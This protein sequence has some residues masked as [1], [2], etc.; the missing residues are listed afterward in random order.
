M[1][2]GRCEGKVEFPYDTSH[3]ITLEASKKKNE[4]R[5][6]VVSNHNNPHLV[7][8]AEF[9]VS[10]SEILN[11]SFGSSNQTVVT[12]AQGALFVL[13]FAVEDAEGSEEKNADLA[14]QVDGVAGWVSRGVFLGVCPGDTLVH[15]IGM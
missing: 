15:S 10:V 11:L 6:E 5:V 12:L 2:R 7:E 8:V 13:P 4:R 1:W 9:R 3:I 14:A